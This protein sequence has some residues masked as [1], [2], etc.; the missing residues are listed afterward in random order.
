M[1]LYDELEYSMSEQ[2]TRVTA[3]R[4]EQMDCPTEERL[5]RKALEKKAGVTALR[6]NLMSRV[7]SVTHDPAILDEIMQAIRKIGFTPELHDGKSTDVRRHATTG[8]CGHAPQ[9]ADGHV[10]RDCGSD[11]A[12]HRHKGVS[13][14][15]SHDGHHHPHGHAE[16]GSE[17]RYATDINGATHE[18]LAQ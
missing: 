4:I 14:Q 8:C 6:F 18:A 15:D 5:L 1:S 17:H 13:G 3:I 12:S 11:G 7:L 16:H 10:L 2:L 9:A